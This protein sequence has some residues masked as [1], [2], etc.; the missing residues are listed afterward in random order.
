M[1]RMK[2][3]M[4][5]AIQICGTMNAQAQVMKAANLE[6]YAKE[7]FGAVWGLGIGLQ[8]QSHAIPTMQGGVETI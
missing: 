5:A 1:K 2:L 7:K 4:L 8:G 3:W 6:K